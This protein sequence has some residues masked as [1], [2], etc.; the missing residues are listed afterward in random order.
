[1]YRPQARLRLKALA[2]GSRSPGG[3]QTSGAWYASTEW[4]NDHF[5]L[6]G[7][8]VDI[9]EDFSAT[10]G[11]VQ[12]TDVRTGRLRGGVD[13]RPNRHGIGHLG[14][15]AGG[16]Y[17]QDHAGTTIGWDGFVSGSIDRRAGGGVFGGVSQNLDRV[18]EQFD[19]EG[20]TI[21]ARDYRMTRFDIE[22]WTPE[23]RSLAAF[24]RA[25]YGDF[26]HGTRLGVSTGPQWR[27]T[28]RLAIEGSYDGNRLSFPGG[29]RVTTHVVGSR[30]V[31]SF[32]TRLFT[33]L[34][35]QWNDSAERVRANLLFH[36][37]YRPGSD[38]YIVYDHGWA[39]KDRL[40]TDGWALVTKATY[41]FG[42]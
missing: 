27:A 26:Y 14:L 5:R 8:Y 11:F 39:A 28:T 9:P 6:D 32:T 18:Q 16:A 12:R 41:R 36:Y 25:S 3:D 10:M 29:D 2:A 30:V 7:S 4:S 17:L 35:A 19:V 40:R 33:K 20:I 34:F 42:F 15:S 37:I 38:L 22:L 31:Y 23:S 13:A 24:S 1:M 21:Q